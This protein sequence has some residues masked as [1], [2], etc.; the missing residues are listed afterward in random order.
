MKVAVN[1]VRVSRQGG[2]GTDHYITHL[3]NELAREGKEFDLFTLVPEQ[4]PDV[5]AHRIKIPFPFNLTRSPRRAPAASSVEQSGNTAELNSEADRDSKH[6]SGGAASGLKI[7]L[8][9]FI[10]LFWTQFVF[11]FRLVLGRYDLVFSPSQIDALPFPPVRQVMTVL[12]V[13][14]FVLN[15]PLVKHGFFLRNFFPAALRNSARILA[16]SANTRKD[17]VKLFGV[18]ESKIAAVPLARPEPNSTGKASGNVTPEQSLEAIRK[19]YGLSRYILCVSGNH[20]HKNMPR[21]LEAFQIIAP[22]TDC[23]LVIAGYQNAAQQLGLNEQREKSGLGERVV[24]LGHAPDG[25]LPPLYRGAE[26]FVFP[27][28][29]EGFGL[30][31]LEA[32]SYGVPVAVSR[33]SSLPEVVGEA[34]VYF[35]PEN[36]QDMADQMLRVLNDQN[37]RDDLRRRGPE[38]AKEFTWRKTAQATWAVFENAFGN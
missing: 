4:F 28:L 12:D 23:R 13:I 5:P 17:L 31:P 36:A 20:A 26:L 22:K 34:G 32:M 6:P 24:F 19:K 18:A 8:G 2:G 38:R 1:A 9:D 10:K 30:P 37:L 16:I 35:D 29:Y 14:P 3:V 25:D 27:S 21:L 11:P 15:L 33:R 7:A